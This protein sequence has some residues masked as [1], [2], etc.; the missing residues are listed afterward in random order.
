MSR[1]HNNRER[2]KGGLP[3]VP[4][5]HWFRKT[6]AWRSLG[7]YAKLLYIEMKARYDGSNNGFISYSY[8]QAE[9]DLGCSNKPVPGA[10]AELQKRG[11]IVAVQ[12]GLFSWKVRFGEGGRATTWRLTE[13]PQDYPERSLKP[14]HDFKNWVAPQ[15]EN[16]T[17]HA[18]SEPDAPLKRAISEPMARPKRA[19]LTKMQ[20]S[21]ARLKR[22]H[23]YLPYPYRLSGRSAAHCCAVR[24]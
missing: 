10:F 3:F 12:K 15:H 13:L 7:P 20:C 6:D 19:I 24:C 8:R 14:T 18:K 1:T 2:A 16:K 17:R 21:M 9:E 22:A 11:F 5:H 4:L 23:L